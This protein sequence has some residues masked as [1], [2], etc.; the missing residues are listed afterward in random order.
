MC[1]VGKVGVQLEKDI[2]QIK[3]F[4]AY[5]LPKILRWENR[6]FIQGILCKTEWMAHETL[7][8]VHYNNRAAEG[9]MH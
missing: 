7:E 6:K 3:N 9:K 8:E 1:E 2:S 4:K 5:S